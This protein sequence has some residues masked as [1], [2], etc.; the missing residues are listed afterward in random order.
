MS[1]HGTV[2]LGALALVG[3]GAAVM[4]WDM[5]RLRRRE[6]KGQRDER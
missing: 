6:K 5:R 3:L 1:F 2:W 4:A